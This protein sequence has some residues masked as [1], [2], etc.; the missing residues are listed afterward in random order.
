M[1]FKDLPQ[2]S[3]NADFV[4]YGNYEKNTSIN[5]VLQDLSKYKRVIDKNL[6]LPKDNKQYNLAFIGKLNKDDF[7]DKDAYFCK[8]NADDLVDRRWVYAYIL[9]PYIYDRMGWSN[10][11][12][13]KPD[14]WIRDGIKWYL[15]ND[16]F[17]FYKDDFLRNLYE[18]NVTRHVYR[19]QDALE[20]LNRFFENENYRKNQSP[21]LDFFMIKYL[22]EAEKMDFNTI[23]NTEFDTKDLISKVYNYYNTALNVDISQIVTDYNKIQTPEQLLDYINVC[24][25]M[26][27][28]MNN[29]TDKFKRNY[30]NLHEDFRTATMEEITKERV[31]NC[32]DTSRLAKDFF[33]KHNIP[34]KLF[35]IYKIENH[36]INAHFF[37]LYC[38][39][40]NICL[41][42]ASNNAEIGITKYDSTDS[43]IQAIKN[44]FWG[45]KDHIKEI[46]QPIPAGVTMKELEQ[47]LVNL[48][49]FNTNKPQEQFSMSR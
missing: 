27:G 10:Q 48:P 49:E 25:R 45:M 23:I 29:K 2:I 44:S 3:Q 47:M 34:A 14:W 22:R 32:C 12:G 38:S 42:E 11:A 20:T 46:K 17:G 24:F 28:Y 35:C 16:L 33:D 43:A 40:K 30:D 36:E 41:F 31:L 8:W 13:A 1:K 21:K 39:G 37:N 26:Y 9:M 18:I 5:E 15:V 6:G 19:H 7:E 4:A